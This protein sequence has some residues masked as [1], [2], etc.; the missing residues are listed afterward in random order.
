[1]LLDKVKIALR[2]S[3]N[4]FD[5]DISDSIAAAKRDLQQSGIAKSNDDNDPLILR[6]IKTYCKSDYAAD[7]KEAERY[8]LSYDLLKNHLSL[9]SDYTEE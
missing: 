7:E 4:A 3:G 9:A 8:R 2:I 6:A 1:M 5:D